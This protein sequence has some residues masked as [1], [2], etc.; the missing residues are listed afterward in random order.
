MASVRFTPGDRETR[1]TNPRIVAVAAL[2]L[3]V[4]GLPACGNWISVTD[5]G[6]VGITVDAAGNPVVAVMTC[7]ESTPVI[8][9]AEVREE[10][11]PDTE[12]NVQRGR[13]KAR[14]A[15]TG[16]QTFPMAD[17]GE[18][19]ATE[20]APGTLETGQGFVVDGGTLEDEHASLG[21]V[22]FRLADLT[23]LSP[24]QVRV[25]GKVETLTSFGTY[26]CD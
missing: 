8:G 12:P 11:D 9:M 10:S 5:A 24:D 18:N 23:G 21:G 15:F 19:W 2:S 25:E 14:E 1:K 16:V 7:G 22:T 26:R 6:R 13:W 17:P 3:L 20:R 4:A